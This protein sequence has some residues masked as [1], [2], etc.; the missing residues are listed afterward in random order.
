MAN[1]RFRKSFKV[2]PGVRINVGKKSAGVSVGGKGFRVSSNTRSGS[3]AS[4]SIPGTGI[5]FSQQLS[6]GRGRR[7]KTTPRN[8]RG[9]CGC[10]PFVIASFLLLP[11]LVAQVV[12]G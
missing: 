5:G 7:R 12:N 10:L 1:F 8:K 6:K 3:R 11:L 9:G 2:A 4:A